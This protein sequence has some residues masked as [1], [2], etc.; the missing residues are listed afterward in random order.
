MT[1]EKLFLEKKKKIINQKKKTIINYARN[2][3]VLR[4]TL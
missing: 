2:V 4:H 1:A 3:H